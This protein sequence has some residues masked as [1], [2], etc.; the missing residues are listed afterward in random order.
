MTEF[1]SIPVTWN[2]TGYRDRLVLRYVKLGR[3]VQD[4]VDELVREHA[5][6]GSMYSHATTDEVDPHE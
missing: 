5:R 2:L 1:R 6:N 4:V 3:R